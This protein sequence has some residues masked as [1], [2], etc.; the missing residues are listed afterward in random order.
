MMSRLER[1]LGFRLHVMPAMPKVP[2]VHP[3]IIV[4]D[5]IIEETKEMDVKMLV[6]FVDPDDIPLIMS[7]ATS[8]K[9]Y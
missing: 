6:N 7:L 1:N 3:I 4:S 8:R 9:K 5:F 2:V